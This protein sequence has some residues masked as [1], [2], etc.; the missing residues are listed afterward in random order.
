MIFCTQDA[1]RLKKKYLHHVTKI[2]RKAN[3][4]HEEIE[5][6]VEGFNEQISDEMKSYQ[7]NSDLSETDAMKKIIGNL[8][9]PENISD[10]FK[11]KEI[12]E[13]L[14]NFN[15]LW[16]K[17]SLFVAVGILPSVFIL[18]YFINE[19]VVFDTLIVGVVT[20]TILSGVFRSTPHGKI[21]LKVSIILIIIF[22][23]YFLVIEF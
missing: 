4:T 17:I 1:L 14:D 5:A 3:Y 15:I 2:M 13:S 21:G 19:E 7:E 10:Y 6:V 16:G 12:I 20:S 11:N 8:E 23:L 18:G 9:K 22:V